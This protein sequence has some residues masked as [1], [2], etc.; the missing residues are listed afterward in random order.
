MKTTAKLTTALAA[1]AMTLALPAAAFAQ[2]FEKVR[3]PAADEVPA[4]P[5]VAIAYGFIWVAILTYVAFV[6]RGVGRVRGELDDVRRKI[7]AANKR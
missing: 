4:G 2:V 6:A 7:D 1:L 3:G 5:F